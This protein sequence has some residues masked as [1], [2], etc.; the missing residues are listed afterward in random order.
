M[1]RKWILLALVFILIGSVSAADLE[2]RDFDGYFSMDVPK[3]ANFTNSSINIT[4]NATDDVIVTYM[5]DKL[6]ITYLNAQFLFENQSSDYF[7]AIFELLY[8][9]YDL[10]HRGSDEN[11]TLFEAVDEDWATYPVVGISNGNRMIFIIGEDL[12]LVKEMGASVKFE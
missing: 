3:G 2:N 1:D 10:Y 5:G 11:M 12:N 6:E 4:E 7:D 8:P 9:G